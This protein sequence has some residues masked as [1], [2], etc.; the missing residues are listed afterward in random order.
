MRSPGDP[1]SFVDSETVSDEVLAEMRERAH[2][3]DEL[4]KQPGWVIFQACA[5][6][7]LGNWRRRIMQGRL[8]ADEYRRAAGVVAGGEMVAKIPQSMMDVYVNALER[9]RQADAE[10]EEV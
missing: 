3:L 1:Y 2:A 5:E 7:E 8:D 6:E 4:A 10:R 9:R